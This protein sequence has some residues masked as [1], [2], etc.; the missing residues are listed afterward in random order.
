MKFDLDLK[1]W[2]YEEEDL[3]VFNVNISLLNFYIFI[4]LLLFKFHF[5][6]Y[7]PQFYSCKYQDKTIYSKLLRFNKYKSGEIALIYKNNLETGIDI[8]KSI[9]SDH[10]P[11]R[12]EIAVL[13]LTITI[14]IYDHRHWDEDNNIYEA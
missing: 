3:F 10:T 11:F 5:E 2:W 6:T 8:S 9:H 7:F 14:Y 1:R 12:F 13:G 4:K